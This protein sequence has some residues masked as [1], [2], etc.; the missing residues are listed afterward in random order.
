MFCLKFYTLLDQFGLTINSVHP[1]A[2][3]CFLLFLYFRFS[4]YL[5]W[6]ENSRKNIL[7]ISVKEPSGIT[8]KGRGPTTRQPGGSLAR[9]HPRPRQEAS[10][11]PRGSSRPPF[12]SPIF[13]PLGRNPY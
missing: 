6:S 8:K 1:G 5:K 10:W 12:P 7:K 9:P 4:G 2:S 11:L 3:S 13:T